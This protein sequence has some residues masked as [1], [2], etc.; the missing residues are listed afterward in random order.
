M[1]FFSRNTNTLLLRPV[2][3]QNLGEHLL[4]AT[5]LWACLTFVT[6]VLVS[7]NVANLCEFMVRCVLF[8]PSLEN[9]SMGFQ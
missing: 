5:A 8:G 9:G 7:W 3:C 2:S 6:S 1:S 4:D